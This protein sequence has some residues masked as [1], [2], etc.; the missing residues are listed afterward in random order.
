MTD[1]DEVVRLEPAWSIEDV[2]AYLRVPVET[3][4]TWRKKRIGPPARRCGKHLRYDPQRVR[5]W[6]NNGDA[7]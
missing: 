2:A 6:L 1:R 5:D 4:R 7:A 3:V